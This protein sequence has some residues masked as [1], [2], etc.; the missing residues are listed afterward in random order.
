MTQYSKYNIIYRLQK[1]IDTVAG[2]TFLNYGYSWGASVVILGALFKLTHL[3]GANIWLFLGYG[4]RKLLCSSYLLSTD[5]FDKTDDGK[6]LPV[7]Y[8]EEE[9]EYAEASANVQG[10]VSS[11]RQTANST[12]E[13]AEEVARH[14]MPLADQIAAAVVNQQSQVIANAEQQ[15]PEW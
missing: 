7:H 6:E 9:E 10:K 8:E 4:N 15:T 1:W 5:L 13:T 2:Q 12:A 14:T 3:P 11:V